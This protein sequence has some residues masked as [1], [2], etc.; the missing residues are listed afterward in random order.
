MAKSFS[1]SNFQSEHANTA[2]L[3]HSNHHDHSFEHKCLKWK[4]LAQENTKKNCVNFKTMSFRLVPKAT[5]K[6]NLDHVPF[7]I[8]TL[9]TVFEVKIIDVNTI[10]SCYCLNI[11]DKHL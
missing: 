10:I 9:I 8:W 5:L 7:L 11:H 2:F 1:L 6:Y 3:R 4:K